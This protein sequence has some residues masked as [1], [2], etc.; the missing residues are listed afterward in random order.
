[1]S[2]QFSGKTAIVTGSSQGIGKGIAKRLAAEGANIVTNSRSRA[3][4]EAVAEEIAAEGGDAVGVE[5]DVTDYDAVE[6]LVETAADEYGGLDIMVN[7]AGL[8]QVKSAEEFDPEEWR[9][10]VDVDLTG[11]FFG[12]QAAGRQMIE[13][14]EGG[15]ILNISS[16]MGGM[17]LHKRAP[18]CASKGGVDNLTR[19]LAVEWAAHDIHVNALAP[20]FIWTEITDQT[21][22]SAGYTD[23]D[24]RDRTPLGR[25]GSIEEMAECASFLVSNNHYVT[26]EILRAD[27]GW[28][29]Y[30]W[31]CGD[32]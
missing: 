1:M 8:T 7:N 19:T 24:I 5:A 10:V 17:G 15:A 28:T 13:Q 20:G 30:A 25:F 14:G 22:G 16:M 4:A 27:G 11:V 2:G 32:Q 29:A 18:Y 6:A 9:R 3:R 12:C 31:G 26:G 21:Q 23:D